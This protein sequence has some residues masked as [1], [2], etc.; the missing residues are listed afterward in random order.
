MAAYQQLF[1][2]AMAH[3]VT[4]RKAKYVQMVVPDE[5]KPKKSSKSKAPRLLFSQDGLKVKTINIINKHP[6]EIMYCL[7]YAPLPKDGYDK[8]RFV[9]RKCE[10]FNNE[11]VLEIDGGWRLDALGLA[12]HPNG[13][14]KVIEIA[15]AS[16]IEM[17]LRA[18]KVEK[19]AY[20]LKVYAW[21]K[22]LHVSEQASVSIMK[23]GPR[24][25]AGKYPITEGDLYAKRFAD[26]CK[27]QA[28]PADIALLIFAG[29]LL[30]LE[31]PEARI[32]QELD[33]LLF[34]NRPAF[35]STSL[36]SSA[37]PSPLA[38]SLMSST[39]SLR[40][41]TPI[42]RSPS[43]RPRSSSA[44]S[45]ISSIFDAAVFG[46]AVP[47]NPS[48]SS[49]TTP[50]GNLSAVGLAHV[51][52]RV[53]HPYS[54]VQNMSCKSPVDVVTTQKRLRSGDL[55]D[56]AGPS[57]KKMRHKDENSDKNGA[58]MDLID[59]SKSQLGGHENASSDKN[60]DNRIKK[61]NYCPK[62]Y[63]TMSGKACL[64]CKDGCLKWWHTRCFDITLHYLAGAAKAR[65]RDGKMLCAD[66][67]QNM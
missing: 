34:P 49:P 7:V 17:K 10:T 42:L 11:W 62:C 26:F 1:G 50:L 45:S 67:R 58:L 16:K 51:A 46:V 3:Q 24:V 23:Y 5:K 20:V 37:T 44:V 12:T 28:N 59:I 60:Q 30:P 53:I 22:G 36:T 61:K 47:Q 65:G 33:G 39:P 27:A 56:E 9:G 21:V 52:N 25:R 29:A 63:K 66:C 40:S 64:Q 57:N 31:D 41:P 32:F 8:E 2:P 19:G 35:V 48:L 4:Y 18:L 6:T 14:I 43:S 38:L 54:M 55:C 13:H 15:P